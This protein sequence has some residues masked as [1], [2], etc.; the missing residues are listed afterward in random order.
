VAGPE[1]G[2]DLVFRLGQGDDHGHLA[3]RRQPIAF[4]RPGFLVAEKHRPLRHE[5]AQLGDDLALAR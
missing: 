4:V 1:D 5:R 2:R 3:I